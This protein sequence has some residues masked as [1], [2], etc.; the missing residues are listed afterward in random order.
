MVS[1][2][3]PAPVNYAVFEKEHCITHEIWGGYVRHNRIFRKEFDVN[4]RQLDDYEVT[5]NHAT[6]MYEPF[7]EK[8]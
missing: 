8:H 6:M 4:G 1:S 5:Q 2:D 7:L 3:K